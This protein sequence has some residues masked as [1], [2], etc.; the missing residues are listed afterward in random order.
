LRPASVAL[1]LHELPGISNATV[2]MLRN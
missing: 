2:E 1:L